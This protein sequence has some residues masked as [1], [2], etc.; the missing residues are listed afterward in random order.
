MSEEIQFDKIIAT[1]IEKE[2]RECYID[3]AMSVIV[4]RALPDVRDGLKPVHRR[5]LY[6]MH[7]LGLD[8]SKP[9]RKSARIVGDTMG[10]YHPHGDSSIYDAMVRMAQEF[11][12]R[13][14]LVDG[15]GNFGSID[16]D[17]PAAQRY[18]EARLSKLAKE[19]LRDIDKDTVDFIPNFDEQEKEPVI[20]PSRFPNLLVNGSS[21]IAV[22][23]ATNIPPHNLGEIIDAVVKI[24]DN[25]ITESRET[26]IEELISIVKGPDFPTGGMILGTSGI[27]EAYRTGRGKIKVRAKT[28]IEKMN[29][30]R[31]RIVVTELPYQVNKARLVEKIAD[32]VKDKRIE[33][34]S[35]LRDESDRTGM[36]IVIEL[37]RDVA[38]NIVL[39]QL[40]KYTQM[41]DNFG[42]ISIALV[43]DEPRT[44][45]LLEM[46][47]YYIEHQKEVV[48][49]RTKFD[50]DKAEKRAHILLGLLIALDN[51][52]EIIRI[53]RKSSNT[54]IAKEALMNMELKV[55]ENLFK[56]ALI[57]ESMQ[58]EGE[59]KIRFTNE[60]AQA[61]IDMRLGRLTGL[62]SEKIQGEFDELI[63]LI[64]DLTEIL[65]SDTRL[66]TVI[67]EELIEIKSKFNDSRRT[68]LTHDVEEF[69]L[70]D[71]IEEEQNVITFT[72]LGY[73]K[74][75]PLDTYRSQNRGGRGIIGM[76]TREE[77][78]LREVFVCSNHSYMM[79]FTSLGK[80]FRIKVYEIPESSRTA[81]GTAIVN[82]LNLAP[83]EK[84]TA[85][86]PV[87]EEMDE[88]ERY[89]F[90][91]TRKGVV[92]KS[93]ASEFKNIRKG[94]LIAVN[95]QDEDKLISVSV[96]DGK[97]DIFIATRDGI[98]V[99]FSEEDVRPTGRASA[100]VRGI[101]INE[102]DKVAAV[103][104]VDKDQKIAF[105]TENGYGKLTTSSEF[106]KHNRGG[107]GMKIYK[108]TQRTGKIAG[109]EM[110]SEEDELMLITSEGV[111][112]RIRAKDISTIGRVTQGVKLMNLD[113]NVTVV[114][115]AKIV[116]ENEDEQN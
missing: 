58:L 26:D 90:M 75:I 22:G 14:P 63:S 30:D 97:K 41:Q 23:M 29:G 100:G 84:I 35:D 56:I 79:F 67:K 34:I 53:V 46:L 77:D 4:A 91:A 72:R 15:H 59:E 52:D 92:K 102:G 99:L 66:H 110:V 104:V 32:L 3:Y 64:K 108:I 115:V 60:Q 65:E 78:L 83:E 39:N 40:F 101:R 44:L 55:S 74:R 21:G 89:L 49:R 5:I 112:I 88:D 38:S 114:D 16:G 81:R 80:V 6:S 98:G 25:I 10:K 76:Q 19:M 107:K 116:A 27:K 45:N 8:P 2:M 50:L 54:Q 62:E 61:I 86:I 18:T 103:R 48:V 69:N 73:I 37:K 33:G 93:K 57:K 82:L 109:V 68:L 11:S 94:G 111:I 1:N 36:R 7:E 105:V 9:Y 17:D 42:V 51:I 47:K 12:M 106:T 70:E 28:S 71:L 43:D 24:I 20:L 96:T 95:L 87:K 85:M 31:E 113:E 13:Y